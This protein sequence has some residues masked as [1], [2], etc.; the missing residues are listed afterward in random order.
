MWVVVGRQ[1]T[2]CRITDCRNSKQVETAAHRSATDRSGA[3]PA[4]H[5][6]QQRR[7]PRV[8]PASR[9]GGAGTIRGGRRDVE[10]LGYLGG[11]PLATAFLDRVVGGAIILKINGKSCRPV[12]PSLIRSR[13]GSKNGAPR[14]G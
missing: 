10:Q 6:R 5:Q 12:V 8:R 14:Q 1:E 3:S 11:A 9:L 7:R 2:W 4:L 13:S